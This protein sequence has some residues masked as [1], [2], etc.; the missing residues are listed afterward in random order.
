VAATVGD[1]VK[2]RLARWGER[3][4]HGAWGWELALL[5][6]CTA[7]VGYSLW[8]ALGQA[9]VGPVAIDPL[10]IGLAIALAFWAVLWLREGIVD[11]TPTTWLVHAN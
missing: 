2:A 7:S 11:A 9:H 8:T 3:G 1:A 6:L 4:P 5:P 10:G